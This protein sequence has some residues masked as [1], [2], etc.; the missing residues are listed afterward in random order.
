M[1][2]LHALAKFL[3]EKETIT[4]DEFMHILSTVGSAG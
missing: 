2:E 3:N 1:T 4:G